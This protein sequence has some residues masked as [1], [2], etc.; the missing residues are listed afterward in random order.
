MEMRPIPLNSTKPGQHDERSLYGV[1]APDCWSLDNYLA[2]VI[3]N[4][5]CMLAHNTTSYPMYLE[6]HEW[7][8]VLFAIWD[9]F[10]Q[11]R[12]GGGF[13]CEKHDLAMSL[14]AE[15]FHDLWD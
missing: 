5:V 2:Q 1:S 11:D 14:F 12:F 4:G 6:P 15:Y 10:A 13:D 7:Y 3:A 9:G 8:A